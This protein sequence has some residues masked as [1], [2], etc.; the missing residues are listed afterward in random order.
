MEIFIGCS[1]YNYKEW[2]NLFYP[3][4]ITAKKQLEYYSEHF[5]TFE[6]NS[7]FYNFP[8]KETLEAWINKTPGDFVFTIKVHRN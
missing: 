4:T 8:R 2:K 3:E 1:G 6:I 5:N 7:T